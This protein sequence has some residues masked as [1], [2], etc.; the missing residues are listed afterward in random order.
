MAPLIK[1]WNSFSDAVIKRIQVYAKHYNPD[2]KQVVQ[3]DKSSTTY[4]NQKISKNCN[5]M[6]TTI[7]DYHK[8]EL[9]QFML[10]SRILLPSKL[11]L[12]AI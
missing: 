5:E 6:Q 7:K 4:T 11:V 8:P 2:I 9:S 1:S 10:K 3:T 12:T